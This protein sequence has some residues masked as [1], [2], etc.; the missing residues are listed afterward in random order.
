MIGSSQPRVDAWGKVTGRA[1]FVDDISVPGAWFGGTV[2]S[3]VAHGTILRIDLEKSFDWS[4]VHVVTAEELPG[5]NQVR[6]IRGDHPILAH[7]S[8]RFVSEPIALIAAPDRPTLAAALSAVDVVI[9]QEPAVLSIEDAL[10]RRILLYGDDNIL[11]EYRIETGDI[12]AGFAEADQVI[13]GCYRTGHQEHLYLETN[14]MIATP[15][16]GGG[17][18]LVGSL[19]CPY[20]IHRALVEALGLAPDAVRV[21]QAATGG[22]F[23]GKEDY[24]S[25]LAVHA[26]LLALRCGNPVRMIHERSEDIRATTK[27]HPSRAQHRTGVRRDGTIVAAEIDLVLDGG[28]TTTLSP[29][30]LSR[31]LLHATGVYRIENVSIRGRVVA[32]HTPPNG[33]FRGFGA[34]QSLFAI[35]RQLDRIARELSIDPVMIRKKNLLRDGDTLPSG[36]R[37]TEGVGASAVLERAVALSGYEEKRVA[38]RG[39]RADGT[40]RGIGLSVYLHGAG[41]TGA[42]EEKIAGKGTVRFSGDGKV[43]ILA[44]NVEMGQGAATVLS[45][46][47]AETLD[48]PIEAIRYVDP[49]TSIVPDSGPTVASRTTMIVGRILIDA[50]RAMMEKLDEDRPVSGKAFLA[51]ATRYLKEVGPLS[52]EATYVPPAGLHWD[53]ETYRGDAY[54]SYAWGADVIEVSVDRQTG[55]VQPIRATVVVEIGRAIHPVLATAQVTGGTLQALGFGCLEEIRMSE[56]KYLNDRMATYLIPT[57]LD[58]PEISVSIL[59]NG[60]SS[61]PFGAKGVGELP[62]DGGAPALAAAIENATGLFF[63]TIPIT[64]ERLIEADDADRV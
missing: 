26:A 54:K 8:V 43:E 50:C 36:Q 19:Q 57:I 27:R 34:P 38:Y 55:Q 15:R 31:A 47:V 30:V 20:Y 61:G 46:I 24:P 16:S 9:R 53:E 1:R 28:A 63:S 59:E 10:R 62:M 14:G 60:G 32:T 11:A 6:M 41:F 42:G 25:V 22:A 17:V 3:P 56:G 49:D 39:G 40:Q 23:G 35:E 21:R 29:V 52:G 44:S 33:A 18:D 58:A 48:L 51:S 7:H 13:E 37:L 12:E 64:P 5:P 4:R 2:R 45:M